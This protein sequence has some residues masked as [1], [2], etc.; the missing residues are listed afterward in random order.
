MRLQRLLPVL[1]AIAGLAAGLVWCAN[2]CCSTKS[3]SPSPLAL[4][5]PACCGAETPGRCQP[6]VGR[7]EA[8][9]VTSVSIPHAPLGAIAPASLEKAVSLSGALRATPTKS[10]VLPPGLFRLHTPLLI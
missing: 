2:P 5:A 3:S 6:S 7:A 10:F 1:L 8:A 9:P 4:G